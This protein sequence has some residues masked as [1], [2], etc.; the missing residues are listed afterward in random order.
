[1]NLSCIIIDDE[2]HA[3]NELEMLLD[4]T[5]GIENLA[6]FNDV[7]SAIAFLN[8]R[9]K[10]DIIFSDIMM[11]KINGLVAAELFRNHCEF[12]I[13]VTA[14]RDFALEAFDAMAAGYLMKPLRQEALMK[15]L[16]EISRKRVKIPVTEIRE[17]DF[18]M[19]KGSNKNSFKKIICRD[20]IYIEAMLNYVK[21]TTVRGSEITYI[22]LKAL[23][24]SLSG[25]KN[26]LR[27]SRSVIISL[28]HLESVDGNTVRM[29]GKSNF[30]IGE[31]YRNTFYVFLRSQ[32]VNH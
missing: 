29:A 16:A 21:I 18:I 13:F 19:V 26:F 30:T 9:R 27:I 3:A 15:Q 1:M 14:H 5:P 17:G 31:S 7:G 8:D 10:V 24:E 32:S 4:R 25:K 22:G 20:I 12:L 2:P 23:E 6:S 28:D 11:P